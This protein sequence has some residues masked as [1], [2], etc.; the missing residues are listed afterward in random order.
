MANKRMSVTE[1]RELGLLQEVNRVF[2]HPK[3][4]ALEVVLDDDGAERFGQVWDWR[5]DPEGIVFAD[6][7]DPDKAATVAALGSAKAEA[8]MKSFGFIVQPVGHAGKAP[9]N[10]G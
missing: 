1:F 6:A 9:A 7:P 10:G 3:G 2:L 8:R 5:D 4:L